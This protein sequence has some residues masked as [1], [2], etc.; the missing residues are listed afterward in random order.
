MAS[1]TDKVQTAL[2]E[3]DEGQARLLQASEK[4]ML[5]PNEEEATNAANEARR[6]ARETRKR[7]MKKLREP[8]G[9]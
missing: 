4:L 3:L 8:S 7:V 5:M 1:M 6:H 2:R 9:R